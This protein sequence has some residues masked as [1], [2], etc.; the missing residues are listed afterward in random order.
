M[1]SKTQYNVEF[2]TD[3]AVQERLERLLAKVKVDKNSV[4]TTRVGDRT[5]LQFLAPKNDDLRDAVKDLGVSVREELIF[6]FEM[7][8]HHWELHKLATTLAAEGINILSLYSSVEGEQMRVVLAV[9]QPANAM[10]L[11]EKLGFEPDYTVY[12]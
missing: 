2:P 11:I 4:V 12:D 6:Q 5:L 3:P 1:P 10:A 9:D 7:P 8:N